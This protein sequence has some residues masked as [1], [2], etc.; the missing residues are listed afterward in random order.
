PL[1]SISQDKDIEQ[2]KKQ[3]ETSNN[4]Y[5][6]VNRLRFLDSLAG[7]MRYDTPLNVDSIFRVTIN[8]AQTLDSIN[9]A[10]KHSTNL[11]N[12]LNYGP[13]DFNEAKKIVKATYP[14]LSKVTKPNIIDD[15]YY[16]AA[17]VYFDSRNFE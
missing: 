17:Y 8:Y 10:I 13:N 4:S 15:F 7:E 16:E 5:T 11:I 2:T 12:F 3:L 9:I 14:L 6:G 1:F